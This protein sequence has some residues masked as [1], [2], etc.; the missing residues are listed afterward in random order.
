MN[1]W[2]DFHFLRPL[3]L[4]ALPVGVW[5]CWYV[6]RRM[7]QGGSWRT[8][9]D[10]SLLPHLMVGADRARRR[11][12]LAAMMAAVALTSLALAG[13]AWRHV[14][15]PVYRSLDARVIVLDLSTS[16]NAPDLPP[17]RLTRARFKVVEILRRSRDRQTGLV[18]FAGDAF[19]V[20]PL[21]QDANTLI[22]LLPS[23]R[24]SVMPVQG[25]RPDRGLEI[26][27]ELLA[28]GGAVRGD[29]VL[30]TDGT[31]GARAARPF[32]SRRAAFSRI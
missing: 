15:Q 14:E 23:L 7:Q 26:A 4:A 18:A 32:R 10:P 3:W 19:F 27:G 13:P 20:S 28:Q 24:T 25:S 16:M 5:F 11:W 22:N 6:W 9:C 31:K 30:V 1:S 2:S 29:V 21:T 17:S 8:A 12:P